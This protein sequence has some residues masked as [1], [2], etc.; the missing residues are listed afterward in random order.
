MSYAA[1]FAVGNV[2]TEPELRMVGQA[3]TPCTRF[4]LAMNVWSG[5]ERRTDWQTVT[6]WGRLAE[7]CKQYLQVGSLVSVRGRLQTKPYERDGDRR[8]FTEIV[9]DAVDFL[10]SRE[11][12][13]LVHDEAAPSETLT[14]EFAEADQVSVPY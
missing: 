14:S 3:Q 1:V 2:G 6:V 5:G 7:V 8:Y 13:G 9:G 10:S 12:G 11:R 4:R